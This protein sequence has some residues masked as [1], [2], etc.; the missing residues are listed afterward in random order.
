MIRLTPTIKHDRQNKNAANLSNSPSSS[1]LNATKNRRTSTS[2]MTE[3][4]K[5]DASESRRFSGSLRR[6]AMLLRLTHG[7][8]FWLG[9]PGQVAAFSRPMRL[10]DDDDL[11]ERNVV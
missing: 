4:E 9:A 2:A 6:L 8:C 10:S 7:S 11:P 5:K 1:T 3:G